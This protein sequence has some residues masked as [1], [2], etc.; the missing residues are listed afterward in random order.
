MIAKSSFSV[1]R[2]IGRFGNVF[3]CVVDG[4]GWTIAVYLESEKA[5]ADSHA[6]TGKH[7]KGNIDISP[8]VLSLFA[9]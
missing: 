1:V 4:D 9:R 3:F 6:Q 5:L 2:D 8:E 7:P